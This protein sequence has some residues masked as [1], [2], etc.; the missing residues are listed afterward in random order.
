MAA[1]A[2]NIVRQPDE[3][4]YGIEFDIFFDRVAAYIGSVKVEKAA[5][6]DLFKS[7][8]DSCS[9]RRVQAL[10]FTDD[11]KTENAV[12]LV[13]ARALL[14]DALQKQATVPYGL[15]MRYRRQ[16]KSESI[17]DFGYEMQ[18]LGQKANGDNGVNS[19]QVI[20]AFCSGLLDQDL[21]AKMLLKMSTFDTLK[22]AVDHAVLKESALGI[23][24]FI[25]KN[26]PSTSSSSRNQGVDVLECTMGDD[27]GVDSAPQDRPSDRSDPSNQGF[28]GNTRNRG[29]S[30]N[31][32]PRE[33]RICRFCKIR[34]HL[35]RDCFKRMRD[36]GRAA[37]SGNS[38][39]QGRRD[40]RRGNMPRGRQDF[41]Q[42]PRPAQ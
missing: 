2:L 29:A 38:Q 17:A 20:E 16:Q 5:Q 27:I 6:F 41:W 37:T 13:K 39:Q 24:N 11:H 26:R 9:F 12:D 28:A 31:S 34:G 42:G 10:V 7:F 14:K 30:S 8:L 15:Q 25:A 33:T 18:V 35:F 4:K 19:P 22:A 21:A 36:T 32:A 40:Q 23:K 1:G 3:F